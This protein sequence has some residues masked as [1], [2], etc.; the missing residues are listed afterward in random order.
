MHEVV[1]ANDTTQS[2]YKAASERACWEYIKAQLLHPRK[3]TRRWGAKLFV[4]KPTGAL[5]PRM[6][7][8]VRRF[9]HL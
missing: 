4:R 3:H 7:A 6:P 1:L 8:D 2:F 5:A 9:L